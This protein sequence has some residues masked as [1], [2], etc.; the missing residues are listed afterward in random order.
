MRVVKPGGTYI[1][2][3]MVHPDSMLD[4]TVEQIIEKCLT[5]HGKKKG[6]GNVQS[7]S[8]VTPNTLRKF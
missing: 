5:I 7:L 6:V 4:V 3:G 8:H 1:L 2:T